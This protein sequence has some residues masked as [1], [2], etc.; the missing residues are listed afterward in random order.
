MLEAYRKHAAE[1]AAMGIPPL[2]LSPEQV[3]AVA[4]LL[5][6]PPKG[7]EAFL[8]DLITH[9][10]PPGVYDASRVKADFLSA[11]A[12]GKDK[13]PV[14]SRQKATELLGTMQGGYNVQTLVAL[15]NDKTLGTVAAAALKKTILMFGAFNDVKALAAKG[16][17]NAKAVMRS[18][19][20]AEWFTVNPEVPK[21]IK[22]TVFK[23]A[24]ETNTGDLSPDPDANTRADIPLHALSMM[25]FGRPGVTPDEV[26]KRGPMKQLDALRAKGNPIVFAGDV[27]G[28]GSSRKS[29]TNNVIWWTGKD[30]PF[31]PNKRYGGFVFGG[32]LA[33]IFYNTMQDSGALPI[34]MDVSRLEM[35]DVVE[36]RPYE[37]KVLRN[38]EVVAQF[39]LKTE[40][41]LDAVRAGGRI[42]LVIGRKLTDDA[43]K[44]LG[45][46]PS[47]LFRKPKVPVDTG[48]GFT[49]AQKVVGL[50]CGLPRGKGVRPGTYCEPK[51]STVGSQDTTGTLTR[52]EIMDLACLK[53]S[54]D[55]VM[56]SFCHTNAYPK[57]SD[58]KLHATLPKFF[59][60]RNGV[61]LRVHDGVLHTWLNRM[62]IPETVGSGGDSH[63]RYP[64]GVYFPAGSGLVAFGAATGFMP[65]DMP[66]SVLVRFKGEMQPGVTLRDLVN[67]IPYYAFKQGHMTIEKKGKKNVFSGRILE[68]EGLPN[69]TPEQAFEISDSTA[70]RSAEACMVRLNKEPIVEYMKSNVA[71]LKWMVANG[72]QDRNTLQRRIKEMEAWLKN[73]QIMEPDADAEYAAIIEIDLAEITE[74]LLACPNDPDDI[75]PLSAVAG[76]KV[77]ET[78]IGSCQVNIGHFRAAAHLLKGHPG[79]PTRLWIVPPSKMDADLLNKEGYFAEFGAAGARIEPPGCSLCFGNQARARPNTTVV[80]TST[81]NF[82]NRMGTGTKVFLASPEL[83]AITAWMGKLPTKAEYLAEMKKIEK[84][85]AKIYRYLNFHKMPEYK[86]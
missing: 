60:D 45:M 62:A 86:V 22:L 39:K 18:W 50:A 53:F 66:E 36:L 76:T 72:Y 75:K 58:V 46:A 25:K 1:R 49:L 24:G 84:D 69:L 42:P 38:G 7:E 52:D 2:P 41:L 29:A 47:T 15:L 63:T 65:L 28:P 30:I 59:T 11:I 85:S 20:E 34:E 48:K 40:V 83:T 9:R 8:L 35:G 55:L 10:V 6:N 3:A 77:D 54:A 13:S 44:A 56:E 23:L 21:S 78:F 82:N 64:L 27:L 5:R 61:A 4:F 51:M 57:P 26:G 17:P 68:I 31:V 70:E 74:P 19:A 80:S 43:R 79:I 33:P 67:A 71:L 73:P 81:R 14:I 16:N 12:L 37:G 32:K